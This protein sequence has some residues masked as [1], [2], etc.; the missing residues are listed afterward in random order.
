MIHTGRHF[1]QIPGPS[2]VP[3][4]VLR[5]INSPVMDHR[6]AEFAAIVKEVLDGMRDLVQTRGAVVMYPASGS[7]GWEASMVNTLSPGDSVLMSE[8]GHFSRLW[9][10]VAER[11]GI[12]VDYLPGT[13]RRAAV[14]EDMASRLAADKNHKYKAVMVVHNETAT[15]TTSDIAEIRRAMNGLNHPALLMVDAVSSLGSIDYRHDEWEVDVLISSSQKGLMLPPGL[16]FNALSQKAIDASKQVKTARSY[17]DWQDML[18]MNRNGFF[19]YTPSINLIFGL[20][21]ALLMLKEEGLANVFRRHQRHAE[22]TRAA[23]RAWGLELVCLE[24]RE[25]SNTVTAVFVPEGHNADD[26]RAKILAN[27]DMSLGAG[28]SKL[29]GKVFRIG[30]LG[31]FNDLMLAGTLAGV[32]MGLRLAGIPHREGGVMAA[33]DSLAPN[34]ARSSLAEGKLRGASL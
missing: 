21:E 26:L 24:P 2:N 5:A 4:R 15:G 16:S 18:E 3:D 33:L 32:E 10:Q 23:V 13:W 12:Q 28:L 8:T 17:W 1:L 29:A 27:F 19:P 22:A 25:Y 20:R 7:G 11:F 6:G 30:H 14:V 31:H 9:R 34:P